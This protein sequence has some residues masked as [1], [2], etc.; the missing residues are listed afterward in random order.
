MRGL[1]LPSDDAV[2]LIE[3]QREV[4][5][6]LYPFSI[7]WYEAIR[8][9]PGDELQAYMGTSQFRRLGE[10]PNV[11]QDPY[12]RWQIEGQRGSPY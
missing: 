1:E 7:V 5:M 3:L 9:T 6:T 12:S 10:W 4:A 2:P 8:I 11:L